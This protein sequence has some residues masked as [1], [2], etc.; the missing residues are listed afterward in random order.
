MRLNWS[1]TSKRR[2][3]AALAILFGAAATPIDSFAQG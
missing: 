3:I 2:L 1:E